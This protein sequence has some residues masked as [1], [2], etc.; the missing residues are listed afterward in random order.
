GTA[1]PAGTSTNIDISLDRRASIT[2]TVTDAATGKPVP[3]VEVL[4]YWANGNGYA[5]SILTNDKGVYSVTADP[6]S[7]VSYTTGGTFY[8]PQI[9]NGRPCGGNPCDPSHGEV[10]TVTDGTATSGIDFHLTALNQYGSI[11]GHVVDAENGLAMANV[12]INC[13]LVSARTDSNGDYVIGGAPS[14]EL[15]G[16][17]TGQYTMYAETDAPYFVGLPGGGACEDFYACRN[18]GAPVQVTAPNATTV[19][20]RMI[21]LRVTSVAPAYGLT[22]GGTPITITGSNF[23]PSASVLV[24]GTA[25]TIVSANPNQIVAVTP[26]GTVG[27]AHVTVSLSSSLAVTFADG[28]TYV[29]SVTF[30]G[31]PVIPGTPITPGH[32]LP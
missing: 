22:T 28:F 9:Y 21:K 12:Y 6:G 3:N 25:A 26:A 4:F 14:A 10:V 11:R 32:E 31:Q 2:G 23:T 27:A 15:P 18:N 20:F 17:Q 1:I 19:D 7:Y 13:G 29:P 8:Q 24:G 16:L 5:T 30:P